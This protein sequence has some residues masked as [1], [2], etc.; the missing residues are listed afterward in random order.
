MGCIH[1]GNKR[2]K[3]NMGTYWV[4]YS[5]N[6]ISHHVWFPQGSQFSSAQRVPFQRD[7]TT[8][9]LSFY[10]ITEIYILLSSSL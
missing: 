6:H 7:I 4:Y 1:Y 10:H 5:V 3:L 9:H 2:L 8:T